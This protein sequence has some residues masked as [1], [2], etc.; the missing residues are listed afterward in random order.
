M[1]LDLAEIKKRLK[2]HTALALTLGSDRIAIDLVRRDADRGRVAQSL[3][4][5]FSAEDV[6]KTPDK[7]GTAFAEALEAAAVKERRCVVCVPPNWALSASTDL[8]EVSAEDLRGYLELRA[9]KEFPIPP[10]ELR[11]SYC[12]YHLPDGKTRAT[13]AAI[14]ARRIESLTKMLETAGCRAM[15]ISLGLE[16]CLEEAHSAVHFLA[17]GDHVDVVITAGGGI[18]ALRTLA[19]VPPTEEAAFDDARFG[20]EIRITLGRL[21]EP[22]RKQVRRAYFA[23]PRAAAQMLCRKLR[24]QLE[25]MGIE[26]P[27]CGSEAIGSHTAESTGVAVAAA[28]A[29]LHE[30]ALPFEFVVAEEN[31]WETILRRYNTKRYRAIAAVVAAAIILPIVAFA[32]RNH[33]ENSLT[34]E[35]MGMKKTVAELETLQ[36]KIRQFR[37][38]FDPTPQDMQILEGLISSFP[39]SGEV[40]AKGIQINDEG[41]VTCTGFTRNEPALVAVLDRLRARKDV[42]ALQRGPSRG[43]NPI[44]FT[45]TYKWEPSHQ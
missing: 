26:S 4:I 6:L 12:A 39:E 25:R 1:K 29:I 35:W 3:S 18:A 8:P 13:L 9:E 27:D 14:P 32:W 16:R 21:P 33:R 22:V 43:N 30:K 31:R 20:R 15:S 45:F 28:Q 34:A 2:P 24:N 44:Q 5:P 17:D 11:L 23:G 38:W 10:A 37:P 36:K 7:V 40:W 19:S 42:T 41:K